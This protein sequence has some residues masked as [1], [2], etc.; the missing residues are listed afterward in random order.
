MMTHRMDIALVAAYCLVLTGSIL[1]FV[2]RRYPPVR[3]LCVG[4]IVLATF[5]AV[6][7]VYL[8]ARSASDRFHADGNP[9]AG[10]F[11]DGAR[12]TWH[13]ATTALPIFILAI[14]GLSAMALLP[15]RSR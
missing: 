6:A 12:Y 2:L 3:G 13:A 5:F 1:P 10:S 4:F 9:G 8:S 15:P 14:G 7:R 11:R